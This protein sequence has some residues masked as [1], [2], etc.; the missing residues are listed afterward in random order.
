MT[1]MAIIPAP[2]PHRWR[3]AIHTPE[4]NFFAQW[5]AERWALP[6]RGPRRTARRDFK[7]SRPLGVAGFGLFVQTFFSSG[8]YPRWSLA[9]RMSSHATANRFNSETSL[10]SDRRFHS[11][12]LLLYPL[13]RKKSRM[14]SWTALFSSFA[15]TLER[16]APRRLE[17]PAPP[18]TSAL[19]NTIT[20]RT[21]SR[22]I[23]REVNWLMR[24]G[25][26]KDAASS[27]GEDQADASQFTTPV[28][29]RSRQLLS[30]HRHE[31]VLFASL[32]SLHSAFFKATSTFS[33]FS[34]ETWN[35][36]FSPD[37]LRSSA[38]VGFHRLL[39]HQSRMF[40]LPAG[41]RISDERREH[42]QLTLHLRTEV[43]HMGP[44]PAMQF[45]QP[46]QSS[47]PELLSAIRRME[48]AVQK[49][50]SL[51]TPPTQNAPD[52]QRLTA[53]VYEQFERQLR[54]ERERR[55]R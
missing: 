9:F 13:H 34:T 44:R 48:A 20:F 18:A 37:P 22:S 17:I 7:T 11:N 6:E 14:A 1:T 41:R 16:G 26:L 53:Q 33:R 36:I 45:V 29:S 8:G 24:D 55:G 46:A 12:H 50:P 38:A 47:P 52:I 51:S 43:D 21:L 39:E 2:S 35:S 5:I 30:T 25:A 19:D 27:R 4:E 32:R 40:M 49:L 54:I 28:V 31:S 23:E 3:G 10:R 42:S 15:A